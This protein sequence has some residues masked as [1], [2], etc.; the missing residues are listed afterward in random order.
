MST[1][2][3]MIPLLELGEKPEKKKKWRVLIRLSLALLGFQSH[4]PYNRCVTHSTRDKGKWSNRT[5]ARKSV[6]TT[7]KNCNINVSSQRYGSMSLEECLV[8]ES[9]NP[10]IDRRDAESPKRCQTY[11][12]TLWL[13]ALTALFGINLAY[14]MVRYFAR[15][16]F[17]LYIL[18][19][20]VHFGTVFVIALFRLIAHLIPYC[21]SGT[22]CI[23]AMTSTQVLGMLNR[24]A[25][26]CAWFYVILYTLWP[27]VNI[28]VAG[29]YEIYPT[30]VDFECVSIDYW[31][32]VSFA[33]EVIGTLI[34]G[35]FWLIILLLRKALQSDLRRVTYFLRENAS[36]VEVSR[37]RVYESYLEFTRLD[38]LMSAWM[39]FLVA[40][41]A[42]KFSC[43]V[44]WN[45][46]VLNNDEVTVRA[47]L[48]N[49]L[50]WL[51]I[52]MFVVL[53]LLAV[54]GL[55]ISHIWLKFMAKAESEQSEREGWSSLKMIKHLKPIGNNVILTIMFSAMTVFISLRLQNQNGDYWVMSSICQANSTNTSIIFH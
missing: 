40:I 43:H 25:T 44:Y 6:K 22:R 24:K 23:Y 11:A 19:Y 16:D 28:V 48:I 4:T 1:M 18:S 55:N 29:A 20:S 51:Q 37:K 10:Y 49:T 3:P 2:E 7:D 52:G 42:F 31:G 33:C 46:F 17:S 39:T 13:L 34:F 30:F 32:V 9:L 8:C 12:S 14:H 38:N 41:T 45:Y 50:I 21:P 47:T 54:D 5:T 15:M 26:P 27:L 35:S 36:K 53:P